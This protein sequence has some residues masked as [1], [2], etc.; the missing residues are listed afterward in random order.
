VS[1]SVQLT[2]LLYKEYIQLHYTVIYLLLQKL[3]Y[4]PFP[5]SMVTSRTGHIL[6]VLTS[7]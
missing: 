5:V 7:R 4:I 6:I 2:M 3:M 1:D